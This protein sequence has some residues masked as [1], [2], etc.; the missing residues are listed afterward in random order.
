MMYQGIT[1]ISVG[2]IS[3]VRIAMNT[4]RPA[5]AEFRERVADQP[6]EEEHRKRSRACA[7]TSEFRNHKPKRVFWKMKT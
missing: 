4:K 5:E 1:S 3:V 7:M 2:I 6:V